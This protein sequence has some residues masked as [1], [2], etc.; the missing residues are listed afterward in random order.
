MGRIPRNRGN[1]LNSRVIEIIFKRRQDMWE[2]ND[3]EQIRQV[4]DTEFDQVL[5][6]NYG[7]GGGIPPKIT[8]TFADQ[9]DDP[10]DGEAWAR[11]AQ[12][13]ELSRRF[14]NLGIP[15]FITSDP[16]LIS[17]RENNREP[18][19]VLQGNNPNITFI[20]ALPAQ[21]FDQ[22]KRQLD[23]FREMNFPVINIDNFSGI[24]TAGISTGNIF[25]I[26]APNEDLL[27]RIDNFAESGYF[28]DK[29]VMLVICGEFN[30][31]D[32]ER[33]LRYLKT[34]DRINKQGGIE[35]GSFEALIQDNEAGMLLERLRDLVNQIMR[36]QAETL[37]LIDAIN[38]VIRDRNIEIL[39]RSIRWDV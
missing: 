19:I 2:L 23:R 32:I 4:R 38:R 7:G 15:A 14:W 12:A 18:P 26:I 25:V 9:P 22:I 31:Q 27:R 35:V 10:N 5:I 30:F 28:K 1:P 21:G 20:D 8:I 37:P 16:K 13:G 24:Y 17:K 39:Q 36:G 34:I 29:A 11:E 3:G 6:S 33:K